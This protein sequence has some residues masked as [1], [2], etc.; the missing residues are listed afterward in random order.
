MIRVKLLSV[1]VL[2]VAALTAAPAMAQEAT[3][4]PAAMGQFYPDTNF[5]TGGYGHTMAPR[6]GFYYRHP[7]GPSAMVEVPVPVYPSYGYAE[8]GPYWYGD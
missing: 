2:A 8:P 1:G 5:Y 4:E 3:Q 7:G 6:P